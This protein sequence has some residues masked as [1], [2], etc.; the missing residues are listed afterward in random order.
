MRARRYSI[1]AKSRQDYACISNRR[2]RDALAAFAALMLLLLLC[3]SRSLSQLP[4]FSLLYC[5]HRRAIRFLFVMVT[6]FLLQI[7]SS[8]SCSSHSRLYR[9][10]EVVNEIIMI[11]YN[12][13][14]FCFRFQ[15]WL[16]RRCFVT[17]LGSYLILFATICSQYRMDGCITCTHLYSIGV[18]LKASTKPKHHV[19]LTVQYVVEIISYTRYQY[20]RDLIEI[21]LCD[22]YIDTTYLP[23]YTVS[24]SNARSSC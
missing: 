21:S 12:C 15:S 19:L 3:F 14:T 20:Y 6:Y 7:L 13:S 18:Q 16:K 9:P 10:H 17:A 2:K 24:I 5:V 11:Y 23:P 8:C 4:S 22:I 1:Y